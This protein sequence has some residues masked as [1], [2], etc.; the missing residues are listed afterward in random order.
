MAC[1]RAKGAGEFESDLL[2]FA[3]FSNVKVHFGV[4]VLNL[5]ITKDF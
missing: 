2:A 4:Y 3:V 5:I 1:F